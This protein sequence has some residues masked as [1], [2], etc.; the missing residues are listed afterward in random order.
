MSKSNKTAPSLP[1]DQQMDNALL[2]IANLIKS[3]DFEKA[4]KI[5]EDVSIFM[6]R[7]KDYRKII[8]QL[9]NE[10]SAREARL[11][12]A[13]KAKQAQEDP[14]APLF[15]RINGILEISSKQRPIEVGRAYFKKR[16]SVKK[17]GDS[18]IKKEG[19]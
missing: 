14:N 6:D 13:E 7:C 4:K 12:Q 19:D 5:T 18:K 8:N 11:V 10:A 15:A 2:E 3:G 9:S 16:S 1:L 17:P